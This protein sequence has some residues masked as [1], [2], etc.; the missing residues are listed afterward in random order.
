MGRNTMAAG[1]AFRTLVAA[2]V[3]LVVAMHAAAEPGITANSIVIGQA[4]GFTGSGA[5]TVEE[6][7]GGAQAH[8]HHVNAKGGVFGRKIVLESMD[9]GFDPKRSPDVFKKLIEEKN[10]FAMF[11]S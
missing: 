8:V 1:N 5:G 9:D 7:T 6:L 11:L 2:L 3:P 10:V 4:A